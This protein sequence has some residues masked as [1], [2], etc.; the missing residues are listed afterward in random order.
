MRVRKSKTLVALKCIVGFVAACMLALSGQSPSLAAGYAPA[1]SSATKQVRKSD[2]LNLGQG[3]AAGGYI[4]SPDGRLRLV[5]Q[6]DGNLV[7]YRT[8]ASPWAALWSSG[9]AGQP[10]A[11]VVMQ[12]DGNLVVY[13]GSVAKWSSNT[14]GFGGSSIWLQNDSNLVIYIKGRAIWARDPGYIGDRLEAGRHLVGGEY[15]WSQDHR[16]FLVQQFDGNL[17]LYGPGTVPVWATGTTGRSGVR[18]EMQGDGNLVLYQGNTAVWSSGTAGQGGARLV[19]QNDSNLVLYVGGTAIWDRSRGRLGAGGGGAAIVDAARSMTGHPYCWGCGGW[20]GPA[21]NGG[22]DCTGLTQYAV[23][24]GTGIVL[25]RVQGQNS[26]SGGVPIGRGDLQP[27]DIVFFGGSLS[28]Y[29]HTGVYIGNGRMIDAADY[30]IPVGEHGLYRNYL[31][32]TRY[33]R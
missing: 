31:G 33:W 23:Y 27:G 7:L 9:T 25:P 10:G 19:V 32:A 11:R 2:H 12:G 8:G 20:R 16:Y 15:A 4:A 6:A 24:K 21:G 13:R 1:K 17:V 28:N 30:G 22:F 5:M 3:L 14:A 29:S 26:S 18:T